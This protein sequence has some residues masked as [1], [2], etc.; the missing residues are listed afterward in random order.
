VRYI[1]QVPGGLILE[2]TD[3]LVLTEKSKFPQPLGDYSADLAAKKA[4]S[5]AD[6]ERVKVSSN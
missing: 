5:V 1:D 6:S 4:K 2:P 3:E